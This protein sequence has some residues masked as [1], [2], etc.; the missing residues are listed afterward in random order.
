MAKKQYC[1]MCAE[2]L[3]QMSNYG[4]PADG[5]WPPMVEHEKYGTL[6]ICPE[7]EA[8]HLTYIDDTPGHPAVRRIRMLKPREE[9]QVGWLR[10]CGKRQDGDE[11]CVEPGG[12]S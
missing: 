4:E 2:E 11:N 1:L 10:T 7:C 6:I 12:H 9:Q 3:Y 5:K 8:E